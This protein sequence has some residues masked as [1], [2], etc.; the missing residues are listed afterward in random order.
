MNQDVMG[1]SNRRGTDTAEEIMVLNHYRVQ[2]NLGMMMR[3]M[4][5]LNNTGNNNRHVGR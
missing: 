4:D 5:D 3:S 1:A 2:E